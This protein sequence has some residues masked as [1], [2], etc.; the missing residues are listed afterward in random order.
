LSIDA[1]AIEREVKAADRSPT[2]DRA[3]RRL[4]HWD[5]KLSPMRP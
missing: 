4:Y 5:L 2:S 3:P 1:D